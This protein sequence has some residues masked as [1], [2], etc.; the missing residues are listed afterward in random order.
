[1]NGTVIMNDTLNSAI[2]S[3]K[4][5]SLLLLDDGTF[6]LGYKIGKAKKAYGEICFTTSMTGYQHTITDPSYANQIITFTFPHIGN[7]GINEFDNET[8][9]PLAQAIIIREKITNSSHAQSVEELDKWMQEKNITGISGVDTRALT[10]II[11]DKGAQNCLIY[12]W[13]SFDELKDFDINQLKEKLHNTKTIESVDLSLFN[14]ES[15]IDLKPHKDQPTIAVIDFGVKDGILRCL[16]KYSYYNIKV[17][18]A[19]SNFAKE[20]LALEPIGIVLSN[21]PGDPQATADNY[22]KTEIKRLIQSQ[23]PIFGICLGHQILAITLGCKT[24]K[25]KNGHRGSN[26][27][28]LNI[29]KATVE[30]TSQNHGFTVSDKDI[31]NEIEVTHKSLFDNT[32]AGIKIKNTPIFSVQYHPEASPGPH[33]SRY[34]FDEFIKNTENYIKQKN[35]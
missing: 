18:K 5:T 29:K 14:S 3:S 4:F 22:A 8:K 13:N 15:S 23:I 26:H 10:T 35:A 20:A 21:G 9:N 32:I 33:D 19:S 11:R 25:M 7:V 30:I 2:N 6:F 17:I 24:I 12:S 1:M 34:L 16:E 28:I 31:P 27:P